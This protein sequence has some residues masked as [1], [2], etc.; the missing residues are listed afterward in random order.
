M[1]PSGMSEGNY[2]I[3]I[4]VPAHAINTKGSGAVLR[5][6]M[7]KPVTMTFHAIVNRK[8]AA[9]LDPST[10]PTAALTG[11]QQRSKASRVPS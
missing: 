10:A 11:T 8:G 4:T 3:A 1:L 6:A 2:D 5:T 7:T 9:H